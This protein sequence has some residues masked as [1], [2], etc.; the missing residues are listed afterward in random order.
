MLGDVLDF[1][2]NRPSRLRGVSTPVWAVLE[3]F[4]SLLVGLGTSIVALGATAIVLAAVVGMAGFA[5]IV[6]RSRNAALA[7]ALPAFTMLGGALV[8]RGTMYPRFF[9]FLIGIAL[10]VL[11]RGAFAS[12]TWT[13]DRLTRER[14]HPWGGRA[15][16]VF[17]ALLITASVAALPFNYRYPKQDFEGAMRFVQ[18]GQGPSDQVAFAGVPGDPYRTAYGLT[19]PTVTTGEEVRQLRRLGRTWLVYTFPRYL[20]RGAPEVAALVDRECG[21]ARTFR[22]T[23][24]GGDVLVCVLEAAR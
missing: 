6:R 14:A 8:G 16:T 1:F 4:R 9:F 7:F 2:V 19:W 20:A 12:F 24:G 3:T 18:A 10:I 21:A 11:V 15:A 17:V 5:S 13:A 23:V 22:G